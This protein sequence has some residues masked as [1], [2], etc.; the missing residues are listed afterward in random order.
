MNNEFLK[1]R[2]VGERFNKH[3]LPLEMLKDFAALE[4]M[5]VEVAKWQFLQSH[6]DRTRIPR[7]FSKGLELHI[8]NIEQGS[9]I[10][11]ITLVSV[12]LCQTT[13]SELFPPVATSYF[14]Q[15]RDAIIETI[16]CAEQNKSSP[17]P[18]ALLGY[19]DRFGRGL[20]DGE[21][22]EF[23]DRN[24]QP[25]KLTPE[26]RKKLI[27]ASQVDEWTEELPLKGRISEA[28]QARM[29]FELE[30]KDG[31]KLKAIFANQ[32]LNTVLEAFNAY[33]QGARVA[34]QCVVKKDKQDRLKSIESV[35][36]ITLL[37]PLDIESR[38]EEL[39]ELH[40]GWLDGKGLAPNH[41]NMLWLG[42][43]FDERFN[44]VLPLPYLYPTAEGGIQVE[45]SL[46]DWQVSLEI[47][48]DS[49]SA[50]W[51][52]FNLVTEEC[53]EQDWNLGNAECWQVLNQA[54]QALLP[55]ENA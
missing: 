29:S 54:L 20:R 19:F 17:L 6:P 9:V 24:N 26:I 34:L 21:Y 53:R 45:W 8:T 28:D 31:N 22:I 40:D 41:E 48:L 44:P 39:A 2:L 16:A 10:L 51:Q 50:Q 11:A 5:I 12:I 18:S 14:E 55:V 33:R 15:A 47:N 35:E 32:H 30:L 43:A 49:K 23:F 7:G 36:H 1:P 42:K 52:A 46:A 38:L 37:D 3:S 25:T 27:R 4:E 13:N